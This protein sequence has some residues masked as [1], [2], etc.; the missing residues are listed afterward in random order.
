[1]SPWQAKTSAAPTAQGVPQRLQGV[2]AHE[3]PGRD[4]EQDQGSESNLNLHRLPINRL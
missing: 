1:M 2:E 4:L 3:T